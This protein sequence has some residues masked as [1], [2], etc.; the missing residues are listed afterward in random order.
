MVYYG[1]AG[2][3]ISSKVPIKCNV[4]RQ[5][6]GVSVLSHPVT[7]YWPRFGKIGRDLKKSAEI[8]K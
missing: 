3:L 7:Y 8:W 6:A 4:A 5:Y 1:K 2:K